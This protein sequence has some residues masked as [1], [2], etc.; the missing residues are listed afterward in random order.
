MF[1]TSPWDD[2][3]F[4]AR[5]NLEP[6]CMNLDH[7]SSLEYRGWL[8]R[9]EATPEDESISGLA[10]LSRL[11]NHSFRVVLMSSRVDGPGASLALYAQARDFIDQWYGCPGEDAAA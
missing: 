1:S 5:A 7:G 2:P 10:D 9:L 4:L 11:G 8:I 3:M 6:A